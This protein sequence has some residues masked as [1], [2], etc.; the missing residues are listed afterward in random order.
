MENSNENKNYT[1]HIFGYG[2]TQIN[3][4]YSFKEA[5]EG[6]KNVTPLVDAIWAKKPADSKLTEKKYHVIHI[7]NGADI[8]WQVEGGFEVKGEEVDAKTLALIEKLKVELKEKHD[9]KVKA[10]LEAKA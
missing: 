2:E 6:F 8:K 3:A 5:T 9:A 7:F 1:I 4:D 10:D